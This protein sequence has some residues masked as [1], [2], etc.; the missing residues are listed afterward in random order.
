[1]Q[2]I[3]LLHLLYIF[4]TFHSTCMVSFFFFFF[5]FKFVTTILF[6]KKKSIKKKKKPQGHHIRESV[7]EIYERGRKIIS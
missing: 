2:E 5:N 1:M 3:I 6:K 4:L 7:G